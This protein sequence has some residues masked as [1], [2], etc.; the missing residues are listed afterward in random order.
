MKD[1]PVLI[2]GGGPVGLTASILLSQAGVRSLLVER[3]SGT[4]IHPKARAINARTMEIF[5]QCGVEAAIRSAGLPL[6]HTGMIIWAKSLAG[7]EIER[8]VPWRAGP[9]AAAV[10]PVRNCLC[11]QDDLEPVLRTFAEQQGTGELKFSTEAVAFEQEAD[12]VTVSLEDHAG[13]ERETVRATY[14]IAADGAQSRFRRKLGTRMLGRANVY[15][16]VNI[17]FNA[18]LTPWTAHRPAGLYFIENERI[19]GSFLTI[20]ARDRWGFLISAMGAFGYT[21]ED[22]T[23][24]RAI[25]IIRV[26]AGVP[27]LQVKVLGTAPWTAS[28]HVAEQYRYGRIFLVG[29]AAHEMPPTGGL[30][31]NTG[32]QDVHNLVWKLAAVLKGIASPW[33]LDTYHDERQPAARAITEQSLINAAS[34]GRLEQTKKSAGARPEYLN[35]QGLIFGA[36]YASQAIVPDGTEAPYVA[37]PVTDYVPSARPG[38]R[39]PHVF[40]HVEAKQHSTIDV[41]GQRFVLLAAGSGGPWVEAANE[42]ACDY[43]LPLKALSIDDS[44]FASAYGLDSSGAVL[45]RPDAHVGWRSRS[46]PRD[47]S[48]TLRDAVSMILC[49]SSS[50]ARGSSIPR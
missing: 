4:S 34:M 8:R 30:G 26:A 13:D 21:A 35:E 16:S 41:V 45:V 25:D 29:D 28:A 32:V 47:P 27:N 43:A 24:E 2:V 40:F 36:I 7:E 17:L 42:L 46:I 23:P 6:N 38:C 37:N 11:A 22:I 33:L 10:S 1:V 50:G 5:H 19:R 14:V 12:S 39:A 44:A 49:T 3:H 15:D 31:M 18:D 48:R 9:Q 20:N